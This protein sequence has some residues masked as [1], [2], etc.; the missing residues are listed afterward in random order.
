LQLVQVDG[1][2]M[3]K[4]FALAVQTGKDALGVVREQLK[5]T[6]DFTARNNSLAIVRQQLEAVQDVAAEQSEKPKEPEEP[7]NLM[8]LTYDARHVVLEHLV[9][10]GISGSSSGVAES[11]FAYQ[12]LLAPAAQSFAASACSWR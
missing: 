8:G 5:E 1:L 12:P 2:Y 7:F 3:T 11:R 4:G 6:P 9:G 10:L